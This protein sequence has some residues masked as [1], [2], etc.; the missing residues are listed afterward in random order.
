[1]KTMKPTDL[2]GTWLIDR[3][4]DDRITGDRHQ[5]SGTAVITAGH[6]REDGQLTMADGTTFAS[7]RSYLWNFHA[8]KIDVFFDDGRPFHSIIFGSKAAE[9]SHYCDPDLYDV[10]YDFQKFPTWRAVW[11]AAGPR[12]DYVMTT[13]YRKQS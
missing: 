13:L 4:M 3:V 10:A 11:T 6:Y 9:D 5:V 7:Q 8:D 12:K 2:V 1:M